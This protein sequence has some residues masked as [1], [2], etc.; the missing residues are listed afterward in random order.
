MAVVV[1][2]S[3]IM[4]VIMLMAVVVISAVFVIM[5]MLS[6]M[7]VM[8]VV[9]MRVIVHISVIP[10][11]RC[12]TNLKNVSLHIIYSIQRKTRAFHAKPRPCGAAL[13]FF[14][15]RCKVFAARAHKSPQRKL[16]RV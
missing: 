10:F 16:R 5:R 8:F 14:M 4:I 12:V 2:M 6:A 3:M 7:L 1:F 13:K 11:N 15:L 9:I